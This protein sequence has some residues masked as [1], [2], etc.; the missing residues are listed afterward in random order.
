MWA[1]VDRF[2]DFVSNLICFL[3]GLFLFAF[4]TGIATILLL[5]IWRVIQWMI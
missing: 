1:L 3:A 2:L 5:S 4:A